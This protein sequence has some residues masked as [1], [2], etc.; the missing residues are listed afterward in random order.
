MRCLNSLEPRRNWVNNI[1]SVF[2]LLVCKWILRCT[3]YMRMFNL[4]Q[5]DNWEVCSLFFYNFW[6]YIG[7][8]SGFRLG[9]TR[10]SSRGI[11]FTPYP[12]SC[13]SPTSKG[14][15]A[16]FYTPFLSLLHIRNVW[17]CVAFQWCWR[18]VDNS[19]LEEIGWL[20]NPIE[21]LIDFIESGFFIW[22]WCWGL[23]VRLIKL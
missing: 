10:I 13:I 1:L 6:V 11:E 4:K 3:M 16:F 5:L 12:I 21:Y 20:G 15:D 18:E 14:T 2:T 23:I 9:F 17:S 8:N 7:G 19:R 22:A